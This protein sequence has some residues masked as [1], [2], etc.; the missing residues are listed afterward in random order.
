MNVQGSNTHKLGSPH[1]CCILHKRDFVFYIC[2][3]IRGRGQY[4]NRDVL[5]NPTLIT[6]QPGARRVYGS[7]PLWVASLYPPRKYINILV[8]ENLYYAIIHTYTHIYLCRRTYTMLLYTHI[9]VQENLF[10]LLHTI[11]FLYSDIRFYT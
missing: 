7:R 10:T 2:I 8:Q 5:F 3:Y 11:I 6:S 4:K 9:L 1:N